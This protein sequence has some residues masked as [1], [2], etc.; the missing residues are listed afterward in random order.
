MNV[1]F[2]KLLRGCACLGI[3]GPCMANYTLVYLILLKAAIGTFTRK[4]SDQKNDGSH[5]TMNL[6]TG[7]PFWIN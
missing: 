3:H 7:F 5:A 1:D 2:V 4:M 6:F